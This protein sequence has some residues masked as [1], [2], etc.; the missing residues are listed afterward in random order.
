MGAERAGPVT[1]QRGGWGVY[2]VECMRVAFRFASF[3]IDEHAGGARTNVMVDAIT[4][5]F[6]SW[7]TMS[8][9]L[10][11]STYWEKR[12]V[13]RPAYA[14]FDDVGPML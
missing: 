1:P 9:A 14:Q 5:S 10:Y 13:T 12:G 11:A 3:R 8:S 2:R 4:V 6:E 7:T